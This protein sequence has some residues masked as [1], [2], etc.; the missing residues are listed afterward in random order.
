MHYHFR[1]SRS[2]SDN[3]Q[4]EFSFL[5]I[6]CKCIEVHSNA[7]KCQSTMRNDGVIIFHTS[8]R[9]KTQFMQ[10]AGF[11]EKC[12]QVHTGAFQCLQISIDEKMQGALSFL[13]LTIIQRQYS[14][15][16]SNNSI[17]AKFVFFKCIQV[18]M[19]AFRCTHMTK[20]D[21]APSIL[22]IHYV[23]LHSSSLID[24]INQIFIL[25]PITIQLQKNA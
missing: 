4:V 11:C 20:K 17:Y 19:S 23:F 13:T 8:E 10:N 25:P 5:R 1:H 2:S 21:I 9:S 14:V 16:T 24:E 3:I 6:A 18:H 22:K 12:I 15:T 7:E